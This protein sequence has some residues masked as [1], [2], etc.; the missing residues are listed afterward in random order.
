ML[1]P[2]SC[3]ISVPIL[4]LIRPVV[5]QSKMINDAIASAK[6]GSSLYK[7][8]TVEDPSENLI[9]AHVAALEWHILSQKFGLTA[10]ELVRLQGK[11]VRGLNC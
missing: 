10:S 2:I 3:L 1:Y 6:A 11:S 7:R 8:A 4:L 9:R 5:L